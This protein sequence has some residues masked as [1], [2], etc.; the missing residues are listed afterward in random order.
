MSYKMALNYL[1][2]HMSDMIVALYN[3]K[4]KDILSQLRRNMRIT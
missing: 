3:I 1:K 4:N 2:L